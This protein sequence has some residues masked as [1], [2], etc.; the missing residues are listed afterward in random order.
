[1]T[2]IITTSP[3]AIAQ[4]DGFLP[5]LAELHA[6]I[7]AL[8]THRISMI[9]SNPRGLTGTRMSV[10]GRAV[11]IWKI[12]R[13]AGR[14]IFTV[15]G[16]G[17]TL[18]AGTPIYFLNRP[19]LVSQWLFG[20]RYINNSELLNFPSLSARQGRGLKGIFVDG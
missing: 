14:V 8:L 20:R 5:K 19:G 7:S 18:L 6:Q 3:D 4:G 12:V 13:G 17:P 15:V 9:H 11:L 10:R 16:R 1:M 2:S